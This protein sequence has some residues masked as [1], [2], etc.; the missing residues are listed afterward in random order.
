MAKPRP[1]LPVLLTRPQVALYLNTSLDAV[2]QLI[3]TGRLPA[4]RF[5]PR[6]TRIYK[7][8]VDAPDPGR[9]APPRVRRG[10]VMTSDPSDPPRF[11]YENA[12]DLAWGAQLLRAAHRRRLLRL[13]AEQPP[14]SLLQPA[15]DCGGEAP[16]EGGG[17]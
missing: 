6:S 17:S 12:T 1:D 2:D 11:A 16:T 13:A 10:G 4:F 5:G 15:H 8:D 14:A 3:Q 7:R 9:A